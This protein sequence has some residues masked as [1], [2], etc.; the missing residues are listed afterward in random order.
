MRYAVIPIPL[1]FCQ[2][3]LVKHNPQEGLSSFKI[4][5]LG[6]TLLISS[7]DVVAPFIKLK[8]I[9]FP[10]SSKTQPLPSII[11]L[12]FDERVAFIRGVLRQPNCSGQNGIIILLR[13]FLSNGF[14]GLTFPLYLVLIP[15]RHEEIII[16]IN[17]L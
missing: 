10:L 6:L 8:E 14:M 9:S 13:N 16:F 15:K 1:F 7:R 11:D 3:I 12:E 17:S 2:F 4:I 5:K